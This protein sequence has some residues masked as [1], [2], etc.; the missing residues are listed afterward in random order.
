MFPSKQ[1]SNQ[2]LPGPGREDIDARQ[3]CTNTTEVPNEKTGKASPAGAAC[4]SRRRHARRVY[5]I[6][7]TFEKVFG[8]GSL[9]SGK[10]P[11]GRVR[12][13]YASWGLEHNFQTYYNDTL[14]WL[15][16]EYGPVSEFIYAISYAQYFAPSGCNDGHCDGGRKSPFN[17][18][19]AS[20]FTSNLP[21]LVDISERLPVQPSNRFWL[22]S[23]TRQTM[24]SRSRW[25]LW[26]LREHS[27]SRP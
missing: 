7:Q 17:Y 19:T 16:A 26:H 12:M 20:E 25:N 18:S 6:S 14:A 27:A 10:N 9:A 8:K 4:W 15:A 22:P 5:E 11:K 13:V 2:K 23:A 1:P 24:A 21:L 3:Q